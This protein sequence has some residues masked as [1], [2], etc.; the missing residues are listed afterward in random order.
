VQTCAIFDQFRLAQVIRITQRSRHG[1]KAWLRWY[2]SDERRDAWF[3]GEFPPRGAWVVVSGSDGYGPHTKLVAQIVAGFRPATVEDILGSECA[4]LIIPTGWCRKR[5]R[6]GHAARSAG[7]RHHSPPPRR[8]A[9]T[10][11]VGGA[12]LRLRRRRGLADLGAI[13]DLC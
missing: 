10:R 3:G 6:V 7:V 5:P 13:Q 8:S 11:G 9:N 1:T 4:A 12:Q 2:W